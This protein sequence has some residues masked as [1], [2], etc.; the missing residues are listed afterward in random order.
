MDNPQGGPSM[1]HGSG[2]KV[3]LEKLAQQNV[4][5]ILAKPVPLRLICDFSTGNFNG[6]IFQD[7][8]RP[9]N[10]FDSL[11]TARSTLGLLNRLAASRRPSRSKRSKS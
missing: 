4:L 9:K 5:Q 6:L 1:E 7:A 2:Q 11:R 8:F 10:I 3:P